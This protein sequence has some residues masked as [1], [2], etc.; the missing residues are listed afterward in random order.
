MR[1]G[2]DIKNSPGWFSKVLLLALI[3]CIPIFGTIVEKGYMFG[4]A[5]DIAWDVKSPMPQHIFG[6]E[7]GRL[8]SRGFFVIVLES[9]L[10]LIPSIFLNFLN[11][12]PQIYMET[13]DIYSLNF[14]FFLISL[15]D[16]SSLV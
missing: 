2:G 15:S 8:Y 12:A 16:F 10:L 1:A 11:F 9:V 13:L 14:G 6:N 5:R 3:K 7:D 4:W